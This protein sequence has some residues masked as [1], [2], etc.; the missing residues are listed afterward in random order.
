MQDFNPIRE[1]ART[2]VKTVIVFLAMAFAL[3]GF[4][5]MGLALIFALSPLFL[6]LGMVRARAV[7]VA[8]IRRG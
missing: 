2:L 4:G 8:R 5:V 3:K 6:L 1:I 7:A